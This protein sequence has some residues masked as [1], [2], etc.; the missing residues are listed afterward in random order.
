MRLRVM[1]TGR[2]SGF[3]GRTSA[4]AAMRSPKRSTA[5]RAQ[6]SVS[7]RRPTSGSM[8]PARRA[9]RPRLPAPGDAPRP[10]RTAPARLPA[11]HG[12]G[13]RISAWAR[14]PCSSARPARGDR[15]TRTPVMPPA[16]GQQRLHVGDQRFA[17]MHAATAAR[18][19]PSPRAGSAAA[20]T[21]RDHVAAVGCR[22]ASRVRRRRRDSPVAGAAGSG[23]VCESGSGKVPARST[24]FCVAMTKNGCGSVWQTP[25]TVTWCSAIAS[26][27]ALCV[28]GGA[29]LI[30]S[31]SSTWANTGPGME[32]EFARRRIEDRHADDVRGQQVGGELHALEVQRQRRGHRTGQRG[33]AQARQ[34]LDQQVAAGEQRGERQPH[35]ARLAQHQRVDLGLGGGQR[36]AERL[37]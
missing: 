15:P 23:P 29:R 21:L 22:Q 1:R 9:S 14:A 7:R 36:L 4:S 31:A 32:S 8:R 34:V 24:G 5:S 2:A 30:S 28:R 33:L 11:T 26:S 35:F 6:P 16:L 12:C 18:A 25:S 17:G 37:G 27:S 10:R 19:T 20:C 13:P 3:F